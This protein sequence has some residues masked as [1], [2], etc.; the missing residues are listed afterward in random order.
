MNVYRILDIAFARPV[1]VVARDNE[2]ASDLLIQAMTR[3]FGQ[4]PDTL[5]KIDELVVEEPTDPVARAALRLSKRSGQGFVHEER[6][7][8]PFDPGEPALAGDDLDCAPTDR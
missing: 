2:H 5:Y 4:L 3:G 1:F 7:F 6:H 8:E